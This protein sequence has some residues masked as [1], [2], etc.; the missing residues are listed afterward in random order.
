MADCREKVVRE[1]CGTIKVGD[2][3]VNFTQCG[4]DIG[5]ISM[6]QCENSTIDIPCPGDG[7]LRIIAC[8]TTYDF[9]AN[10]ATG[11]NTTIDLDDCYSGGGGGPIQTV[12]S[13]I[14]VEMS[15]PENAIGQF[16]DWGNPDNNYYATASTTGFFLQGCHPSNIE[17][18][19]MPPGANGCFVDIEFDLDIQPSIHSTEHPLYNLPSTAELFCDCNGRL[20]I[21]SG[22]V[23]DVTT[24]KNEMFSRMD[25]ELPCT[26]NKNNNFS[27]GPNRQSN[28]RTTKANF[29]YFTSTGNDLQLQTQW[30]IKCAP[31]LTFDP[32]YG[33][34]RLTPVTLDEDWEGPQGFFLPSQDEDDYDNDER[35]GP[36]GGRT[37]GE[38]ERFRGS[39]LRTG[40][41][42][43]A[44]LLNR[45]K[46]SGNTTA[47]T[48]LNTLTTL[49]ADTR[50][51]PFVLDAFNGI[52]S[53]AISAGVIR[54]FDFET[55]AG[56]SL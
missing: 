34:V 50:P 51:Y 37:Q 13:S 22:G 25:L 15:G 12:Y 52:K 36:S 28:R 31:W 56:E 49:Y 24:N 9:T 6:D 3:L 17:T 30:T 55:N 21:E 23:F 18:I 35:L 40:M 16:K 4:D 27:N 10:Q 5:E 44:A 38:I 14:F 47:G 19:T 11:S 53:Q 43:L 48:L 42:S 26:L 7:R 54:L 2:G 32:S 46:E 20:I 8:G 29:I 39:D 33:R 41:N 1:D 45:A